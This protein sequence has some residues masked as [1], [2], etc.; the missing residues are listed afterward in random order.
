MEFDN[1]TFWKRLEEV[2]GG[3]S[4]VQIAKDCGIGLNSDGKGCSKISKW[5]SGDSIPDIRDLMAIAQTYHCS[6]DYLVGFSDNKAKGD[7]NI[8]D[9][10]AE[11]A[12]NVIQALY[13]GCLAQFSAENGCIKI[14]I[15]DTTSAMLYGLISSFLGKLKKGA[16]SMLQSIYYDG[17]IKAYGD[18]LLIFSGNSDIEFSGNSD[19][20]QD[21]VEPPDIDDE[22]LPFD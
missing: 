7:K 16:Q 21:T 4:Q 6:I 15:S 3:K 19:I 12:I 1:A 2:S 20:E 13:V 22:K 8:A 17:L 10:T 9:L 18:T 14:S 11:D 5:K